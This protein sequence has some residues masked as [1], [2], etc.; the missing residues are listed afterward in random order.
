M[1]IPHLVRTL[2]CYI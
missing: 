2:F 1:M